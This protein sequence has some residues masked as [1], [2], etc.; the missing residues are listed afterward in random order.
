MSTASVDVLH[1]IVLIAAALVFG[2]D[3]EGYRDAK[4]PFLRA[5]MSNARA[6]RKAGVKG[7]KTPIPGSNRG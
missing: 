7:V 1:L 2:D 5:V 3:I 6:A 4:R